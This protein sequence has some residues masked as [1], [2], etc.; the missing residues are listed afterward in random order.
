LG[1]ALYNRDALMPTLS[2]LELARSIVQSA[3]ERSSGRLEIVH[4]MP[5]YYSAE[6]RACMAGWGKEYLV[7]GPDGLV[8][9]CHAAHELGLETWNVREH[10]LADI[11]RASPIF[12][13][14]R[15]EAWM[16]EPCRSCERRALDFGGCRCQA[17]ALTG[18][19]ARTDPACARSPDHGL[20]QSARL[21]SKPSS[22]RFQLRQWTHDRTR[23]S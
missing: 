18:S 7:V 2:Q 3:R 20:V 15:G 8:R 1:W 16:P 12:E 13:A 6:P 23:S 10:G 5:D 19:A 11:W 21:A 4:V 17:H 9:P 14:F 22:A